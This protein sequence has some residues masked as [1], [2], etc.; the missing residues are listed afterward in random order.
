M[1]NEGV[2]AT[3]YRGLDEQNKSL[4]TFEI[5]FPKDVRDQYDRIMAKRNELELQQKELAKKAKSDAKFAEEEARL[6]E[7]KLM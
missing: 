6:L 7:M 4:T 5:I 3:Q 2:G 1:D